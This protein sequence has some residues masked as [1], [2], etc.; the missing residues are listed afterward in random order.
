[1]RSTTL[2]SVDTTEEI[3]AML[4]IK[5]VS[6]M[7]PVT[8]EI[9]TPHSVYTTEVIAPSLIIYIRVAMSNFPVM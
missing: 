2:R 7:E 5:I 1:M 9:T 3:V 8:V 6:A 4:L